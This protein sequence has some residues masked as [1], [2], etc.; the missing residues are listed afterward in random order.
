MESAAS[1]IAKLTDSNAKG[2]IINSPSYHFIQFLYH[3]GWLHILRCT[4]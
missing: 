4:Y 3:L 1:K 2:P